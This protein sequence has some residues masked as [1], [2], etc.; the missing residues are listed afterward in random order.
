MLPQ[1][2]PMTQEKKM[3]I[4]KQDTDWVN[5]GGWM[6]QQPNAKIEKQASGCK[7]L[8]LKQ[9]HKN[10]NSSIF[11]AY[12]VPLQQPKPTG[13]HSDRK[14]QSNPRATRSNSKTQSI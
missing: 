5:N 3:R 14:A 2:K 9:G 6:I 8:I 7:N 4:R 12:C 1:K 11:E 13:M 10:F